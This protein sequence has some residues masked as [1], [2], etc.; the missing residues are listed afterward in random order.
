MDYRSFSHWFRTVIFLSTL[1]VS[2]GMASAIG[3]DPH[4]ISSSLPLASP[5]L[6]N[7]ISV[8][9]ALPRFPALAEWEEICHGIPAMHQPH[10]IDREH[11]HLVGDL[12]W[13][14]C[15][16]ISHK[17]LGG[18]YV[19]PYM[20]HSLA[21]QSFY[22]GAGHDPRVDRG[23]FDH[24]SV[25]CQGSRDV[26]F[27]PVSIWFRSSGYQRA[28][29][30]GGIRRMPN[31]FVFF[32]QDFPRE[33]FEGEWDAGKWEITLYGGSQPSNCNVIQDTY[34]LRSREVRPEILSEDQSPN[35]T[36]MGL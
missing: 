36:S 3:E 14:T 27:G 20:L 6:V 32:W 12:T 22:L 11:S 18:S 23:R 30:F 33:Q 28:F 7:N 9:L 5:D 8:V 26:R 19:A 15:T 34:L 21:I 2:L 13:E 4:D 31:P 1:S 29:D 35:I 10:H 25:R 16:H 17:M 24:V